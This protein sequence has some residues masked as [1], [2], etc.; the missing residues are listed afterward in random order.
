MLTV[1]RRHLK[2]CEHR[3]EGR[4]Y[5]RCRCPIWADG[6]VGGSD[7]RCSLSTTD[8]ERAQTTIRDWEAAGRVPLPAAAPDEPM[9]VA[10]ACEQFVADAE[11]RNLHPRTVYKYRL[12]F[13]QFQEF[14]RPLRIQSFDAIDL[15]LLVRYRA[16]W[17]DKNLSALKKL[18]RLR[19]FF[20][21]ANEN[22]WIA[23]N[24]AKKLKNP[25]VVNRPTLPYTHADMVEI[26]AACDRRIARLA[27]QGRESARRL[28]ALILL[29]RYSGLRIGDAVGCPVERLADGKL[30]LYTQKTGTHVHCPLP[31]FVIKE[32]ES[33]PRRHERYWFWSGA[34]RLAT[35]VGFWRARLSRLFA[36]AG[37]ADGHAHRFRDTFAVELLL[38]GVPIEQVAILL[39]HG[40][41]RVT[42]R[43]YAPWV[44][45]RQ[46]QAEAN[47]RR[48][49]ARDPIVLMGDEAL[50]SGE[51]KGTQEVHGKVPRVM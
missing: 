34:C 30:R 7:I 10:R 26:L 4:G 36:D 15:G 31:D 23:D 51:P 44:R 42:E 41:V 29:L 33:V 32:L 12:M 14:L 46:E 24:P 47:V 21:F 25:K 5:R 2:R 8:W 9:T 3:T 11:A 39:G 27:G 48:T 19:G 49:W 28:R 22:G 38:V 43:Y 37:I 20:K 45:A 18:E 16:T 13:R 40:S 35:V 17:A 6:I 1:Y 50:A